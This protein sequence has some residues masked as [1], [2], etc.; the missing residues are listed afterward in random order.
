M[1]KGFIKVAGPIVVL[2]IFFI[3]IVGIEPNPK[4]YE[5]D[6]LKNT[7]PKPNP[8]YGQ[9]EGWSNQTGWKYIKDT[10][11][12][13]KKNKSKAQSYIDKYLST[14]DDYYLEKLQDEYPIEYEDWVHEMEE[15]D[16]DPENIYWNLHH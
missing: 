10:S 12:S 16:L 13:K 14:L 1:F 4:R 5:Y 6:G 9:V 15:E 3:A 7:Y 8:K 11:T 2:L